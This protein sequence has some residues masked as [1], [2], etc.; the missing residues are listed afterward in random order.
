MKIY[1]NHVQVFHFTAFGVLRSAS[2]SGQENHRALAAKGTLWGRALQQ[3][4][5]KRLLN[6]RSEGYVC[7]SR[8]KNPKRRRVPVRGPWKPG[9]RR[10]LRERNNQ[11]PLPDP[12]KIPA[13]LLT[14]GRA[15]LKGHT[16]SRRS[17]RFRRPIRLRSKTR[18]TWPAILKSLHQS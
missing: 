18:L 5:Y 6:S 10:S 17:P 11:V 1:H 2:H 16:K 12:N 3:L 7:L 15:P 4:V 13:G 14:L 9:R 8:S